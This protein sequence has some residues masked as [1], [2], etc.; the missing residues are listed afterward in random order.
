MARFVQEFW[1][2]KPFFL[3]GEDMTSWAF[4]GSATFHMVALK[5]DFGVV[6]PFQSSREE[7]FRMILG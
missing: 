2:F 1:I 5:C 3:A 7:K 6:G 4:R